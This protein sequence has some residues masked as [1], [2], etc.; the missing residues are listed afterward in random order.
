MTGIAPKIIR[1]SYAD[2]VFATMFA[3]LTGGVFLTGLALHMGMSEAAIGLLGAMPYAATLFQLP[4]SVHISRKGRRKRLALT[5]AAVGRLLWLPILAVAVAQ[6]VPPALKT[7]AVV[8]LV[9]IAHAFIS[10][11]YVSW[12][13]WTSDLVPDNHLGRFFGTRNM[14]NGMAGMG[15]AVG[16]GYLLE[17]MIQNGTQAPATAF[18]LVFMAAVLF[19]LTSLVF[20]SRIP[21][22]RHALK[23]ATVDLRNLL[24]PLKETNFRRFLLYDAA[25]SFSVYCASPFFA[26][27]FLRDLNFSYTFV[28]LMAMASGV[29]DL[30]GMRVWGMV[31]DRIRNKAVIQ[32]CSGV[33]VFLP[34]LW[35]FARPGDVLLPALLHIVGGGFWAG[36]NLC[37]NNMMLR[38]APRE[39]RAVCISLHNIA[40]GFGATLAPIAA[41]ICITWMG[42]ARLS[43]SSMSWTPL[44]MVL[45]ASSGLRILS[46]LLLRRV[47]EPEAV[48]VGRMIRVLR[49]V[50]GLNTTNGFSSPLH[51]FVEAPEGTDPGKSPRAHERP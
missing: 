15:T 6:A 33:A 1:N 14:L 43:V 25:W 39:K 46:L 30:T 41:G 10:V 3:T 23:T 8:I 13:S 7:A 21:D 35:T 31:S 17:R 26:L 42:D 18:T 29:A 20:L 38:I 2:G 37:T 5:G 50:R 9:F 48:P 27:Y 34:L 12:L 49:N 45:V 22:P 16:F 40:T 47:N 28:A 11:S 19:G 24:A 4:A 36:I 32:S 44:Q 51:P